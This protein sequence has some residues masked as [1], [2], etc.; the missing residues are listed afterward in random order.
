MFRCSRS[1]FAS[2]ARRLLSVSRSSCL[3]STLGCSPGSH[4]HRAPFRSKSDL[5]DGWSFL[6]SSHY[7]SHA[8]YTMPPTTPRTSLHPIRPWV[9]KGMIIERET[10][11]ERSEGKANRKEGVSRELKRGQEQ[12]GGTEAQCKPKERERDGERSLLPRS[13]RARRPS[14][15]SRDGRI[16]ALVRFLVL[17]SD[18]ATGRSSLGRR[19][20]RCGDLGGGGRPGA[21]GLGGRGRG[22]GRAFLQAHET[23]N[24]QNQ[25]E[26]WAE[27]FMWND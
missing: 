20:C 4:P 14:R 10:A 1:S 6:L 16:G 5:S 9:C 13:S 25:K 3:C 21:R 19:R 22:F 7:F 24:R 15:S 23:E 12:L 8:P 26:N 17:D 18:R 27:P 11:R 2:P